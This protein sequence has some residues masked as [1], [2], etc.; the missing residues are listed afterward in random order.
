MRVFLSFSLALVVYIFVRP[1]GLLSAELAY[2]CLRTMI[3]NS[4]SS[5]LNLYSRLML[6]L[7]LF[8]TCPIPVWCPVGETF[9]LI[10]NIVLLINL[11]DSNLTVALN[12][13]D[14]CFLICSES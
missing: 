5:V 7:Y 6:G 14:L 11:I 9:L 10:V 4:S 1:V 13:L 3:N 12:L 8:S 2:A